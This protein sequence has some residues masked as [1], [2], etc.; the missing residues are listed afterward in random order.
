MGVAPAQ[1]HSRGSDRANLVE[2]PQPPCRDDP[3]LLAVMREAGV[4]VE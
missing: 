1:V 4:L 2:E 3:R